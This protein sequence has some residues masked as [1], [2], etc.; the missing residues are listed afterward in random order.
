MISDTDEESSS[1]SYDSES[2]GPESIDEE[3][4]EKFEEIDKNIE[5]TNNTIEEMKLKFAQ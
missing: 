3:L 2:E 1:S 4:I 5:K